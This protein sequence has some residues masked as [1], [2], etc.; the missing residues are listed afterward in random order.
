VWLE[1]NGLKAL[2]AIS[3]RLA[4]GVMSQGLYAQ[5]VM[6]HDTDGEA[7]RFTARQLVL[8]TEQLRDEEHM[9]SFLAW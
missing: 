5:R 7:N 1:A 2:T 8:W 3:R 4:A 9:P 6:L